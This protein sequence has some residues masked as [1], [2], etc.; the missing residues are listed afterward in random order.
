M[1]FI[2]FV[3]I[4]FP[5]FLFSRD[6]LIEDEA[7]DLKFESLSLPLQTTSSSS[8]ESKENEKELDSVRDK[9]ISV[10]EEIKG[11]KQKRVEKNLVNL[12]DIRQL[13]KKIR[14]ERNRE[15]KAVIQNALSSSSSSSSV[16]LCEEGSSDEES[17]EENIEGS[18]GV[19]IL[20]ISLRNCYGLRALHDY[21]KI[22][23]LRLKRD[24]LQSQLER[25]EID[26][27]VQDKLL[28]KSLTSKD[29]DSYVTFVRT[30]ES[31]IRY[32]LNHDNCKCDEFSF[33]R[34]FFF[35]LFL[36]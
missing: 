15:G 4:Y 7:D 3:A 8:K 33:V 19:H 10:K 36:S 13:A 12:D 6:C 25:V 14:K 18:P 29:K 34:I 24:L 9:I 31:R 23:Y 17:S 28:R 11:K 20:E 16:P 1:S 30:Y 21:L 26:L 27:K 2:S 32:V 35:E 22:P 5:I